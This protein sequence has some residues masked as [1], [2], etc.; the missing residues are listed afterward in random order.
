MA[1]S[2]SANPMPRPPAANIPRVNPQT[3]Q[4]TP[5]WLD[6]E[7]RLLAWLSKLAAAIP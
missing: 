1:F 2:L 4:P 7:T 6:Y 3:G 5:A